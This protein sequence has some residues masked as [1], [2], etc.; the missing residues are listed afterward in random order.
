MGH[1][2]LITAVLS[3]SLIFSISPP[4]GERPFKCKL[5]NFASTT[6]SH[7]SRHKRVHTGEKPY[8]C[9]WCDYRYRLI[10]LHTVGGADGCHRGTDDQRVDRWGY[11]GDVGGGF[12]R[13]W[14][15]CWWDS[16]WHRGVVWWVGG[17]GGVL[18]LVALSV[19]VYLCVCDGWAGD[20]EG[21]Q[22]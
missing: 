15:V 5:C 13:V 19:C 12:V 16:R 11:D 22:V 1:C 3:V 2:G 14:C 4:T 18:M 17:E 21:R 9:P 8:R 20:V 10:D 6:Q 7:L